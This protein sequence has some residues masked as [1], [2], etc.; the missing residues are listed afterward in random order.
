MWILRGIMLVILLFVMAVYIHRL[1]RA[2]DDTLELAE[3]MLDELKLYEQY[4]KSL[5]DVLEEKGG[6][7]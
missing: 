1:E 3:C 4:T 7:E 6:D 2:F 5:E